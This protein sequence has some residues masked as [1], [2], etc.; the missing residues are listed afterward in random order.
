[1]PLAE[2]QRLLG[3]PGQIKGVLVSNR[4]HGDAAVALT[5]QVVAT[6]EADASQPLGLETAP[7]KQDALEAADQAGN[8][9]MSFF[10]TFGTR[11][12]SPRASC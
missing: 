8:A 7:A 2:A 11:S 3:K 9:F 12:R 5:D 1:M 6:S 4:G 10:T